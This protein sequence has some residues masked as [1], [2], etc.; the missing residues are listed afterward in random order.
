MSGVGQQ[1]KSNKTKLANTGNSKAKKASAI[2]LFRQLKAESGAVAKSFTPRQIGTTTVKAYSGSS[3][4]NITSLVR[5]RELRENISTTA[6]ATQKKINTTAAA[7]EAA[8]KSRY[9]ASEAAAKSRF[10]ET[11]KR[12]ED[13][14][15]SI[16]EG[17]TI[18]LEAAAQYQKLTSSQIST[19]ASTLQSQ[20]QSSES[21]I[22]SNISELRDEHVKGLTSLDGLIKDLDARQQANI[23][24]LYTKLQDDIGKVIHNQ[25]LSAQQINANIKQLGD[26]FGTQ[27]AGI[28]SG[29]SDFA[30]YTTDTFASLGSQLA[31]DRVALNA[32]LAEQNGIL[33]AISAR[34]A[35]ESRQKAAAAAANAAATALEA[36]IQSFAAVGDVLFC[37]SC[38][39]TLHSS[40]CMTTMYGTGVNPYY[41]R[42]VP[43]A[44]LAAINATSALPN[45]GIKDDVTTSPGSK[46]FRFE[47]TRVDILGDIDRLLAEYQA[48]PRQ[49]IL[50]YNINRTKQVF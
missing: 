14:G 7:A 40:D 15:K 3:P 32:Q 34:A 28:Q 24:A 37:P 16:H 42:T 44:V 30:K 11:Q 5:Q 22:Q 50:D 1:A 35:E 10:K 6:A 17:F 46:I 18:S 43:G 26:A 45:Y 36:R 13:L 48:N 20:I 29:L 4:K 21:R 8:A 41:K 23:T 33:N 19:L 12:F 31:A 25:T 38:R 47:H 9:E 27:L 39:G 2:D 49:F